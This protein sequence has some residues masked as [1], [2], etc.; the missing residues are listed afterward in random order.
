MIAMSTKLKN[1]MYSK[2]NMIFIP[3]VDITLENGTKLSST[4]SDGMSSDIWENS[5]KYEGSTSENGKFTL[6]SCIAPRLNFVLNNI[7]G[8]Y[9]TYDFSNARLVAKLKHFFDDGT[10]EVLQIGNFIVDEPD[11][12]GSIISIS[13]VGF[14]S[15]LNKKVRDNFD[16]NRTVEEI[17]Y[18]CAIDCGLS[19]SYIHSDNKNFTVTANPNIDN[20][21]YADVVAY[22]NQIMG[23][24]VTEDAYGR[25]C[26]DWYRLDMLE[27][28]KVTLDGGKFDANSPYSSGDNA[29]GGDF[30]FNNIDNEDGG[31]FL[32]MGFYH[33]LYT[34]KSISVCT[35]D[36]LIDGV[37]VSTEYAETTIDAEGNENTETRTETSSLGDGNY[38]LTISGNPLIDKG[39]TSIICTFLFNKIAGMVFRPFEYTC[40]PDPSIQPGDVGFVY[41][42]NG[43]EYVGFFSTVSFALGNSSNVNCDAESV[44]KNSSQKYSAEQKAIS[45]I[46]QK[47]NETEK[48]IS[49][50]QLAMSQLTTLMEQSFG[51]FK[52]AEVQ[53]DGSV[54]YYLHNKPELSQSQTQWKMTADG[55]AVSTD[56]G[57]TWNAGIDS[58]GN[59]VVNVLNAIGIN[60]DW[61]NA[62][63]FTITKDGKT[64]FKADA[65]NKT[66]EIS[67]TG[68]SL[69]KNGNASFKGNV[70]ATKLSAKSAY[71]IYDNNVA[72]RLLAYVDQEG[73][74][75]IQPFYV[76]DVVHV[77]NQ[78]DASRICNWTSSSGGFFD[79]VMYSPTED[80]LFFGPAQQQLDDTSIGAPNTTAIR[81]KYV[82]LY[83]NASGGVYLGS[84]G[85]TAI[86]SDENLKDIYDMDSRY[87]DFFD[88][89]IPSTYIYK[90]TERQ[91]YH[92][93]HMGFGARQVEDALRKAGLTT[94][95]FA[96]VLIDKD[97]TLSADEMGTEENMH[98]DELYSLRYE[99]FIPITIKQV[100]ELKKEVSLL[101]EEISLLKG[102]K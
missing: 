16:F 35:D 25:L 32:D 40:L 64:I 1:D 54:I 62:G 12:N 44:K 90:S 47:A 21:T 59:A 71:Y 93:K 86:T 30:S 9:S 95:E 80:R 45:E 52:T 41:D 51:V 82:R 97:V 63:S 5:F 31:S 13:A 70:D 20:M 68:L 19:I 8:K 72:E 83:T 17:L 58:Q 78:I 94:E 34:T 29:D 43:N 24:F 56:G 101:K 22:C 89:L 48:R 100:Q 7:D 99:E 27:S 88:N 85:T 4:S 87:D 91:K 28:E 39:Q 81:G 77:L 76:N 53:E 15:K 11:Y 60:A 18:N 2:G 69:D 92:R 74:I 66:L 102:D 37:E 65:S 46:K 33:S 26:F 50:Y 55:L 10:T 3:Y 73:R 61:I 23:T 98:F 96:G 36:V 38:K 42:R 14:I 79:E 75:Y 84:S 49:S 67:T 57:K 6:G